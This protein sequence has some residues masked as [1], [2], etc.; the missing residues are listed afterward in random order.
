METRIAAKQYIATVVI[1]LVVPGS[2][3]LGTI[4]KETFEAGRTVGIGRPSE[5]LRLEDGQVTAQRVTIC[6]SS[7]SIT[8]RA[9]F[10]EL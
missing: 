6:F 1:A 7:H 9:I 4:T 2:V 8:R 3:A 5:I 10:P